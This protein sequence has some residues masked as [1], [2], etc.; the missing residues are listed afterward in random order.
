MTEI[1]PT[2]IVHS[3]ARLGDHVKIGPYCVVGED[4]A[5]DAG[6][7]LHNHVVIHTL[8]TIGAEN[9]IFPFSVIGADPKLVD[10]RTKVPF[11][12]MKLKTKD[13]QELA[14]WFAVANDMQM[15]ARITWATPNTIQ[16]VRSQQFLPD[17]GRVPDDDIKAAIL[18]HVGKH[19]P[20]V[21][22]FR[23]VGPI[24]DDTVP[25]TDRAI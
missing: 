13:K 15:D 7:V 4:V 11:S 18:E 14:A 1:H 3:S 6:T 9:E 20:P 5:I 19:L 2:A 17:V 22:R 25:F 16:E 12:G 8:T 23:M 21:E 24:T 10:Q